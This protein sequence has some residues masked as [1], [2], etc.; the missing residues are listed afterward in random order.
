M[1]ISPHQHRERQKKAKKKK[2]DTYEQGKNAGES[3]WGWGDQGRSQQREL[4]WGRRREV[5]K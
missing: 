5:V 4:L 3:M 2:K 1:G